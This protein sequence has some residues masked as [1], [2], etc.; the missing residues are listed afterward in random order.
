MNSK[1]LASSPLFAAALV[2]LAGCGSGGD[3]AA[4]GTGS[5]DQPLA[6]R[7]LS[8]AAFLSECG[9]GAVQPGSALTRSP[10][11]QEVTKDSAVVAF[12]TTSGEPVLMDV[13][14]PD[15]QLVLSAKA[16]LET[17]AGAD[18]P[19]T[20]VTRVSG[21]SPST[22]YCY[23]LRG[24]TERAGFRSAPAAGTGESVRFI[25]LG[26]SG[27]GNSDQR[28]VMNQMRTVPF[29][30]MLHLGDLAYDDGR[31]G[32]LDAKYFRIYAPISR[33]F[34]AYV[35]A[36]NHDYGTDDAMPLR[37]AFVLPQNGGESGRERWYSF[38]RGDVHFVALDTERIGAEQAAWLDQDLQA[39]QLPWKVVIGH[40]P[41]FSS[42]EHGGDAEF[43][44]LFV[45]I[46]RSHGVDLVLSGHEHDYERFHPIDGVTYVVSGGGG[47]GTRSV[48]TSPMTAFS[49][50]VLHF[51]YVEVTRNLLTLH[52][53]DGVGRE[54]DQAVVTHS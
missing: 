50:A 44:R 8:D 30:L 33:S 2:A 9:D 21:L 45:P 18:G 48:G 4:H 10:Y 6:T 14:T 7:G 17:A 38:D 52:A 42:G 29:D 19:A 49:E 20:L 23:A 24:F 34:P 16:E 47:R 46:I 5:L 28:S 26:D 51:V 53:I 22:D 32:E 37:Q 40:R 41:P 35:V 27:A 39:N 1:R 25:A 31:P 15:G 54:F 36:G 11:L 43:Q 13:T 12:S 3:L